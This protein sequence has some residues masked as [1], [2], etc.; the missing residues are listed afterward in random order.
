MVLME[1]PEHCRRW[2]VLETLFYP[3]LSFPGSCGSA[4][5]HPGCWGVTLPAIQSLFTL[6]RWKLWLIYG[7]EAL[8]RHPSGLLEAFCAAL[9]VFSSVTNP[10]EPEKG[11]HS[12]LSAE[13]FLSEVGRWYKYVF[14]ARM[15]SCLSQQSVSNLTDHFIT[16]TAPFIAAPFLLCFPTIHCYYSRIF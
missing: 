1:S 14:I 3:T 7:V 10:T 4:L 16:L 15:E 6:P 9:C 13:V 12:L 11:A 5:T 8:S 2:A